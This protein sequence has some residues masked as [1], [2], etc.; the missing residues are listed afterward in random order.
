LYTARCTRDEKR[1]TE[2]YD[3]FGTVIKEATDPK[4]EDTR[5][6]AA[7][8]R[9]TL[10]AQIVRVTVTIANPPEGLA[11]ELNG[12]AL[13]A[14]KFGSVI[15][16]EPGNVVVTAK[17][18]GYE[19]F[20]EEMAAR[21][22]ASLTIKIALKPEQQATD[23]PAA[24]GKT[25]TMTS[26]GGGLRLAGIGVL[27][28]GVVGAGTFVV[29]RIM[30]DGK[31]SDLQANCVSKRCSADAFESDKSAGKT[32]D[33]LANVGL[34]VGAVGL[35]AGAAMIIFGGPTQ[36]EAPKTGLRVTPYFSGTA[37]GF[38]GTF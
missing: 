33:V 32:L 14:D 29:A 31:Y 24:Q 5:D 9:V 2:A 13:A 15:A 21:E 11:V 19:L 23:V 34:V 22:G 25:K 20:K 28:V 16:L 6:V 18:A 27:A 8:E 35:G 4:Y 26:S 1:L 3:L 37:A 17:A 36:V 7:Q 30:G 10:E 38:S 12:K